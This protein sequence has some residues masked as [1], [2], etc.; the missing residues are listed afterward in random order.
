MPN[1][2]F[3]Q[4]VFNIIVITGKM[5]T[6]YKGMYG[7]HT[8]HSGH[9]LINI[10]RPIPCVFLVQFGESSRR[11]LSFSEQLSATASLF[12]V[13]TQKYTDAWLLTW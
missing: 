11:L 12:Q 9:I 7:M 2:I 3:Y 13:I 1:G 8:A 4:P 10:A 6:S 5:Y